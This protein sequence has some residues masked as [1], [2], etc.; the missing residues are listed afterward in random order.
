MTLLDDPE[1]IVAT[2]SISKAEVT[3]TDE[4]EEAA[5]GEEVAAEA[6]SADKAKDE[7]GDG[8]ADK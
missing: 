7:A 4:E 1:T 2:V 8:A 5:E 3:T 6:D